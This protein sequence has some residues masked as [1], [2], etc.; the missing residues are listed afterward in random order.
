MTTEKVTLAMLRAEAERV[1]LAASGLDESPVW[2]QRD[3]T[4]DLRPAAA[5]GWRLEVTQP[6]Q[7]LVVEANS[8]QKARRL[9][10]QVLR[11][12]PAKETT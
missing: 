12:L 4:G 7:A 1:C 2:W 6:H 9:M 11:G 3:K 10:L 5:G 8:K